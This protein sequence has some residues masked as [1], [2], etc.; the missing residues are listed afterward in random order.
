MKVRA[1]GCTVAC[2]V[3]EEN[4]LVVFDLMA[5]AALGGQKPANTP[6]YTADLTTG[7]VVLPDDIAEILV[8]T[9]QALY[10]VDAP[11][12]APEESPPSDEPGAAPSPKKAKS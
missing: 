11:V 3:G 2:V 8:R 12:A 1:N 10:V 7:E 4:A 5:W 9:G 6:C